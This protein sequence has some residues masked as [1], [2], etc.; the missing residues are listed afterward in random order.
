MESKLREVVHIPVTLVSTVCNL[1]QT[2]FDLT[3]GNRSWYRKKSGFRTVSICISKQSIKFHS[4]DEFIVP[5][6]TPM[7]ISV[8]FHHFMI[9]NDY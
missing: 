5:S 1:T 4:G 8:N 6:H 9:F 3:R 7:Y 2:V